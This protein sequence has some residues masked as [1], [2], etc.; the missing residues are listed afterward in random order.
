[1][2]KQ[3][4]APRGE[5]RQ[6]LLSACRGE[7]S[8]LALL[9]GFVAIAPVPGYS[10]QVASLTDATSIIADEP[11]TVSR[12]GLEAFVLASNAG[13]TKIVAKISH[14]GGATVLDLYGD[15]RI[16]FTISAVDFDGSTEVSVETV[17]SLINATVG[18]PNSVE[19]QTVSLN[20]G[21]ITL[22]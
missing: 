10:Q 13:S 18:H 9:M 1:M 14:I 16:N 15:G 2:R 4:Q 8:A 12:A 22:Q 19:A 5:S 7:V 6:S 3:F 21:S 20:N 11:I 17:Q